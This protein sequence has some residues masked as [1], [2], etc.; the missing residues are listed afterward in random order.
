MG[1]VTATRAAALVCGLLVLGAGG[2]VAAKVSP[3]EAERL[4]KDLT[5]VGA[6]Q[7]GNAQ[8]TIPEWTGGLPQKGTLTADWDNFP[9]PFP[10]ERP[11]FTITRANL[12]QHRDK[13]SVGHLKMFERF[14][15]YKMNIYPSHRTVAYPQPIYAATKANATTAELVGGNPDAIKGARQGFPFPIPVSG[16]EPIWNHRLKYRGESV[17]RY[18]NQAIVL[19]NGAVA[20]SKIIEDVLFH[21]ASLKDPKP[22]DTPEST[23]LLYLFNSI[24][25]PRVAG[26][27]ILA[28]E[29]PSK[30]SAWIYNPQLRRLRRA[31]N[32]AYDNPAEGTDG[33]QFYDQVDMFNGALD[34]Y[35][36]KLV[37]KREM[38]IGYNNAV[39]NRPPVKYAD[40][41]K[42][43]H[44]NQD[45]PRYELHR[46]WVV[47]ASNVPELRH[48]FKKRVFYIDEDSWSIVMVDYYDQRDQYWKFHEGFIIYVQPIQFGTSVPEVIYDLQSGGYFVTSMFS[49]DK[50]GDFSYPLTPDNFTPD[51]VKK[52]TSR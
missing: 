29:H 6:E 1:R 19:P 2:G 5:P 20:Y 46:V 24:S 40:L 47:E 35:T 15:S 38:Y 39:M 21:Y 45:L 30:R 7:A 17:R 36:W 49:E 8:G 9:D 27:F 22:L 11:L 42:P 34:R 44:L 23:F 26:Q 25:P 43:G 13:L 31:P 3:A 16:A 52:L 51:A 28:W 18:N 48:S 41:V 37:G 32:V 10:G 33:N 14:P 50:P 12:A 4:G